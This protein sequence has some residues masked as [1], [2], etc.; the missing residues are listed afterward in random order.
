MS[1]NDQIDLKKI[2]LD[3]QQNHCYTDIRKTIGDERDEYLRL[4]NRELRDGATQQPAR[5]EIHPRAS[6]I[7]ANGSPR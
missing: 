1:T 3:K 5:R 6:A 2:A 4:G 7:S